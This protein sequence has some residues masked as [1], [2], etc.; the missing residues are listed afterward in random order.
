M[1]VTFS[2][3]DCAGKSTQIAMLSEALAR[4]GKRVAPIWFRPGYSAE[5]NALRAAARRVLP[6]AMPGPRE[7]AARER[8]FARPGVSRAWVCMALSDTFLQYA[9]KVRW[10]LATGRTVIADRYL[11]DGA[12]DLE[13]RFPGQRVAEWRTSRL[14]AAMSTRPRVSFLLMLPHDV[15]LERMAAKNEP[16]PDPPDVRDRRFAA[17]QRLAASGRYDVI[18]ADRPPDVVHRDILARLGS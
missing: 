7:G 16:F 10:L 5:M 9:I 13:F 18:D 14:V 4:S 1:L 3:V 2:G 11:D 12:L 17:Y 15:M 8:A 6:R